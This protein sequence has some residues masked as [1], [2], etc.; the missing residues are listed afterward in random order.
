MLRYKRLFV[1]TSDFIINEKNTNEYLDIT[2]INKYLPLI[3]ELAS[4]EAYNINL[5][6][7]VNVRA[8]A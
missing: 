4:A 5:N 6:T 7:N 8:M 2:F 3:K 1:S